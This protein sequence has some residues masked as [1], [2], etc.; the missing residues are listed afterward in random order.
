MKENGGG[1]GGEV[2]Q[3]NFDEVLEVLKSMK[4]DH[5]DDKVFDACFK[6]WNDSLLND[7][8]GL[9]AILIRLAF[10]AT[11]SE[12]V[13]RLSSGDFDMRD[14]L[15]F[16]MSKGLGLDKLS[17]V[18]EVAE[19]GL[20]LLYQERDL[21]ILYVVIDKMFEMLANKLAD[22]YKGKEVIFQ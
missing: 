20:E 2:L 11:I 7:E 17:Q 16:L 15:I 18:I 1:M 6:N 4:Y 3:F 9:M 10:F 22:Q 21:G 5:S 8:K 19:K 14:V 13:R 12:I